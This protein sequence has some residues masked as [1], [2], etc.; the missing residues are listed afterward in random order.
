MKPLGS[1]EPQLKTNGIRIALFFN[2]LIIKC[3]KKKKINKQQLNY[4]GMKLLQ[5]LD[6]CLQKSVY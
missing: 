6:C 2:Y 5:L 3:K 1:V 4:N